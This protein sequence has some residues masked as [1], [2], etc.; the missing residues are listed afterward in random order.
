MLIDWFTVGAQTLNFLILVW[1]MKRFLYQPILNAID[2]REQR[3]AAE[4]AAADQ[5]KAEA[6]QTHDEFQ[7]K[8]LLFDQQR[9]ELLQQATEEVLAE[10]TRLLDSARQAADML[11]T[12]RLA[13][14]ENEAKNLNLGIS[15]RIQQEVFAITRKALAD[16]ADTGLEERL[17]AVFTR[18][19]AQMD[20][21]THQGFA[22]ALK[23]AAEPALLR[24]AFELPPEQQAIIQNALNESFAADIPLNF[25]TA[26][27]LI[28][29]I[30]LSANGWKL[31]WSIADYLLTL[32][33]QVSDLFAAQSRPETGDVAK[34]EQTA[35]AIVTEAGA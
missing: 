24:C 30:E 13:T 22:E 10:R 33:S 11:H 3:I 18:R 28:A 2:Q 21:K 34:T 5:K 35:K 12:Q 15:R 19:L 9:A 26:P 16:L 7:Q 6:Q 23:T 32:E 29:G 14:L 8:N 17:G 20:A 1:L 4:L 27:D 25:E 31:A